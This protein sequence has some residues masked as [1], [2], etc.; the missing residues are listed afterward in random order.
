V[1]ISLGRFTAN[2]PWQTLTKCREVTAIL[3]LVVPIMH[4]G[5]CEVIDASLLFAINDIAN[6]VHVCCGKVTD[7]QLFGGEE[8]RV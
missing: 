3:T 8:E 1:L 4:L 6:V 7:L 2:L 5:F